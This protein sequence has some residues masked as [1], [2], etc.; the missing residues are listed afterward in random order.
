MNQHF[1]DDDFTP[2]LEQELT[3][4]EERKEPSPPMDRSI[5]GRNMDNVDKVLATLHGHAKRLER[6]IVER[7]GQLREIN[8]SIQAF[9]VAREVLGDG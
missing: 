2:D 5:L 4:A 3:V 6:E 1:P 7:Q 8:R 9:N